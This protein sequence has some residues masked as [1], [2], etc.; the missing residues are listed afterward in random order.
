VRQMPE[1]QE[2]A[3]PASGESATRTG[4]MR[5]RLRRRLPA[6][7][8]AVQVDVGVAGARRLTVKRGLTFN[9]L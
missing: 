3:A 8:G 9:A 1:Q 6:R 5:L 4:H 7:T 2:G